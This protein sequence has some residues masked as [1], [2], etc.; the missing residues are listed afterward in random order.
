MN[1]NNLS[2]SSRIREYRKAVDKALNYHGPVAEAPA[3]RVDPTAPTTV[4]V[5]FECGKQASETESLTMGEMPM[6]DADD[7]IV[8][9]GLGNPR[10]T[11]VIIG[12]STV[13]TTTC[14][15][16]AELITSEARKVLSNA[17]KTDVRE[18][19]PGK[20]VVTFQA[21]LDWLEA[22][23]KPHP[24]FAREAWLALY[25][26]RK[27]NIIQAVAAKPATQAKTH[28]PGCDCK[29]CD[30]WHTFEARKRLNIADVVAQGVPRYAKGIKAMSDS[31]VL[32]DSEVSR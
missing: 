25:L 26:D 20:L 23:S 21:Y 11:Q 12:R 15:C 18:A 28:L 29:M 3:V 2:E 7:N 1:P 10:Y 8:C 14:K 22:S 13:Y 27:T 19:K 31:F 16:Q 32:Y 4:K 24:Y 9:D 30:E 6:M 5:C 17:G